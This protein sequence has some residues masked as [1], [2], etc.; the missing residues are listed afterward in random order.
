MEGMLQEMNAAVEVYFEAE[1]AESDARG[2]YEVLLK[3]LRRGTSHVSDTDT[4]AGEQAVAQTQ[5]RLLLARSELEEVMEV[6]AAFQS[7]RF[8]HVAFHLYVVEDGVLLGCSRLHVFMKSLGAGIVQGCT[9]VVGIFPKCLVS[10]LLIAPDC[11]CHA[12]SRCVCPEEVGD[13][14]LN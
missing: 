12:V 6:L 9:V 4:A 2:K 1:D 5:A 7:S 11:W 13:V 10:T 8:P 14:I 3:K